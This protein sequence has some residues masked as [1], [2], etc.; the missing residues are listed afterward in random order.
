[1][2]LNTI[3]CKCG[4]YKLAHRM[5]NVIPS[6]GD[7]DI[8]CRACCTFDIPNSWHVFKPDNLKFLEKE[9]EKTKT[10]TTL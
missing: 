5:A 7:L 4:H 10:A 3:V 6:N 2:N 1:M 9:Y 8:F